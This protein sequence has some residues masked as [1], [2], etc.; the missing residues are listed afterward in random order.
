MKYK[1]FTVWVFL[2]AA[3]L[4]FIAGLRDTFAPGFFNISPHIPTSSDIALNFALASVL[5]ILALSIKMTGNQ[6]AAKDNK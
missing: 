5:V 6:K 1:K 4:Y 2:F 3:A